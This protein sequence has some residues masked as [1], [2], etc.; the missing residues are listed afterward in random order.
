MTIR[1]FELGRTR[2][3]DIT[4]D[5]GGTGSLRW[6]TKNEW[7]GLF[8]VA[9]LRLEALYGGFNGEPLDDNSC[10]YIFVARR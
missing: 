3:R 7:L 10:E 2:G 8:D 6:A 4:L 1:E 5:D 9:G